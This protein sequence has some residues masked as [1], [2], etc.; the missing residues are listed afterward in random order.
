MKIKSDFV[1][2]S[3]STSFILDV[4]CSGFL[5]QILPASRNKAIGAE[6][7][8]KLTEE[9]K[10]FV[11]KLFPNEKIDD[12]FTGSGY[13]HVTFDSD[14][15]NE[16]EEETQISIMISNYWDY[17]DEEEKIMD[18]KS[19]IDIH[20]KPQLVQHE[21]SVE[22]Y[23]IKVIKNIIKASG[24]KVPFS[25]FYYCA[26]PKQTGSGGWNGGDP[27]GKYQTTPELMLNETRSGMI[28]IKDNKFINYIKSL[29][30]NFGLMT[31]VENMLKIKPNAFT[32]IHDTKHPFERD[33]Y[34]E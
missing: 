9:T 26:S 18:K 33:H 11:H 22:L 17:I 12:C 15:E 4:K 20:M 2:N 3:S 10:Q 6:T 29:K 32:P 7:Y 24:I 1:T 28:V 14:Y 23:I 31:E 19:I 21:N 30:E 16:I 13:V 25:S 27:M 5:P 34:N 8:R